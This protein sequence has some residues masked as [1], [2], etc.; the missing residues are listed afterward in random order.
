M[1]II[2]LEKEFRGGALSPQLLRAEA[3]RVWELYSQGIVREAYFRAGIR[4]AVLI[5]EARDVQSAK[6]ILNT[7]PLL[8]NGRIVFEVIPL[9]PYDGFQRLFSQPIGPA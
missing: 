7:L 1:K 2:A 8:E 3:Q 5:L 9:I 4:E 6:A